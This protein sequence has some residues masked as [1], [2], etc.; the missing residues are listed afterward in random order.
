[1]LDCEAAH[2]LKPSWSGC[3]P[4]ADPPHLGYG[5][6]ADKAQFLKADVAKDSNPHLIGPPTM[7]DFGQQGVTMRHVRAFA[8]ILTAWACGPTV[9]ASEPAAV[10]T[11][12]AQPPV[13]LPTDGHSYREARQLLLSEG[14]HIAS[15]PVGRPDGRFPELRCTRKDACRASFTWTDACGAVTYVV[16]STHGAGRVVSFVGLAPS[17]GGRAS[18][19]DP[20]AYFIDEGGRRIFL[21]YGSNLPPP[22][23]YAD[24]RDGHTS[25]V[26]ANGKTCIGNGG[27]KTWHRPPP[28]MP[29]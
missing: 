28:P 26:R 24:C 10:C 9:N 12:W 4:K 15:D 7:I 20:S 17:I 19:P 16:I 25:A 23:D 1:M 27:V 13:K 21:Q 11:Y 6:K 2:S 3:A 5:S 8:V 14:L 29:R 18:I 22:P